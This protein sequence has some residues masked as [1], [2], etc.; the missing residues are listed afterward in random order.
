MAAINFGGIGAFTITYCGSVIDFLFT[1]RVFFVKNAR[2]VYISA[3][4]IS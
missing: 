3:R 1:A 4:P 2:A